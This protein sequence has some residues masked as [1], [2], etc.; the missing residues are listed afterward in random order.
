VNTC[1]LKK[2]FA[3]QLL[4]SSTSHPFSL[5]RIKD[6]QRSPWWSKKTEFCFGGGSLGAQPKKGSQYTGEGLTSLPVLPPFRHL[7]HSLCTVTKSLSG[8]CNSTFLN[9]F[10][11]TMLQGKTRLQLCIHSPFSHQIKIFLCLSPLRGS[12]QYWYILAEGL[13]S[14]ITSWQVRAEHSSPLG[15]SSP[16]SCCTQK[17]GQ[18][19]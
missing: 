11:W 3:A 14:G 10:P 13:S 5:P 2:D 1:I 4:M 6:M 12:S 17:H 18:T 7:S 16:Q 15:P 19:H 8:C 9:S